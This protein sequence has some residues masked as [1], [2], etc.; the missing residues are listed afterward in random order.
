VVS[1]WAWVDAVDGEPGEDSSHP[2]SMVVARG[3][4]CVLAGYVWFRLL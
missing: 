2:K 3:V 1:S 4:V